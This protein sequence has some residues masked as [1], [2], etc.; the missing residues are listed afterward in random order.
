LEQLKQEKHEAVADL[1]TAREEKEIADMIAGISNDRT[2]VELAELRDLRHEAKATAKVSRELAGMD[3][4]RS[5]QEFL[6][7][8]DKSLADSEFDALIGLA[9]QPE[10]PRGETEKTRLPE[11]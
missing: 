1:I 11:K 3:A 7:Y 6:E 4:R 9:R 10:Q 5:E 8:A 2:S